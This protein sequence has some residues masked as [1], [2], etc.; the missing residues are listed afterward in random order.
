MLH[1]ANLFGRSPFAPLQSHMEKVASCVE[2]LLPLFQAVKENNQHHVQKIAKHIS[3]LEHAADITKNSIRNNLP[4]KLFLS[5]GRG[6]FLEIL[7]LQ[8]SLADRA[9][10][11]S[12][13]VTLNS[14]H[15]E[16]E[17][18]ELF[19][20]FLYKNIETFEEAKKIIYELRDLLESSFGGIE[21]EKVK[22]MVDTV[23]FREHETDLLQRKLLQIFFQRGSVMP[24]PV[25]FQWQ[26]II[27]AL[28]GLSNTS[29]KLANCVRMTLDVK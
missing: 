10:D 11:A 9:E 15:F 4:G 7:S 2:Q 8:D 25:F 14:V 1:I 12:V 29:E 21:A 16:K 13:L 18:E 26:K 28:S 5:M 20:Q 27:E 24:Y 17:F 6:N 19:F 3:E 23:A 22:T